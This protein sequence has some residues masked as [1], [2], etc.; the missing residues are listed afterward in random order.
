MNYLSISNQLSGTATKAP[1]GDYPNF[2]RHE[3]GLS[4]EEWYSRSFFVDQILMIDTKKVI[5]NG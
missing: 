3:I 5:D 4:I 2:P 1:I